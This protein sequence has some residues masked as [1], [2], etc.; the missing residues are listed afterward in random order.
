VLHWKNNYDQKSTQTN[1]AVTE[2][3]S[4]ISSA[5]NPHNL[6]KYQSTHDKHC[7][8]QYGVERDQDTIKNEL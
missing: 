6:K 7:A 2:L 1:G 3:A 4:R 8:K 5:N